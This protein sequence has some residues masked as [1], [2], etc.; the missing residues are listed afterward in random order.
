MKNNKYN[1]LQEEDFLSETGNQRNFAEDARRMARNNRS[2]KGL[3][4]I[5]KKGLNIFSSF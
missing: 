1:K 3:G 4:K 2:Q 5:L